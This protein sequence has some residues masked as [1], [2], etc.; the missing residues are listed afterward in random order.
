MKYMVWVNQ[1]FLVT[2]ETDGSACAAEHEILDN[3][4]GIVSAQAFDRDSMKTDTFAGAVFWSETI[5]RDELR[6]KSDKYEAAW[7]SAAKKKD[8]EEALK[9]E[10][11]Q[12]Q[13][14]IQR[15]K[16]ELEN[17]TYAAREARCIALNVQSEMGCRIE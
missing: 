15:K 13:A 8:E 4:Q 2:V 12:L 9:N 3:Y 16:E 14:I 5:S 1:K 17:K 7:K 6:A 10:I 11:E